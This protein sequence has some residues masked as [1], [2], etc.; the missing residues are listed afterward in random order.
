[1]Q[2]YL[3]RCLAIVLSCAGLFATSAHA[4]PD[5][6][7]EIVVGFAPGGGTDITART[8]ATYLE[9]ELGGSVVVVNKSGA[10][11]A[12]GLSYVARAKPD[13]HTLGMTNM[14]GLLTVPIEREAGYLPSDFTYLANLVRDPCAFSVSVNSPYKTLADL[15]AAAKANPGKISVSTS[16][17]GTDDHLQMV[18]FEKATGTKL[19]HVP[20]NGAAPQRNAV[21]GGH[22]DVG[23]MNIGEAMPYNGINLRILAQA[24]EV[25]SVLAPEVPTFKEQGVDVVLAS[26]RGLV[27]PKGL[28]KEVKEK[29][30]TALSKIAKNPEF[31]QQ[32]RS[33]FTEIDYLPSEAWQARLTRA[34]VELRALWKTQR[35]AD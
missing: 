12:I 28:S 10:S 24:A 29:L 8:L 33:Q 11:G 17:I 19:N 14:P 5:R 31:I 34:D 20:F 6:P 4:W 1:M 21:F 27:G 23:G 18:F 7:I 26:E 15:V 3:G 13:G 30:E 22:T 25:R 2:R 16:G 35:W 32:I 9:K